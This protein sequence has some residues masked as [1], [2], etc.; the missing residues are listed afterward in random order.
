MEKLMKNDDIKIIG[1]GLFPVKIEIELCDEIP[2]PSQY[3]LDMIEKNK[4]QIEYL[5]TIKKSK[6]M[7]EIY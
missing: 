4:E 2:L 1:G 6:I 7:N 3:A 5:K